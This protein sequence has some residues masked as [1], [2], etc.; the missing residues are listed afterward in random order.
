MQKICVVYVIIAFFALSLFDLN[1][2]DVIHYQ[3]NFLL[4]ESCADNTDNEV[5][6]REANILPVL[7]YVFFSFAIMDCSTKTVWWKAD[8]PVFW[9]CKFRIQSPRCKL[10]FSNIRS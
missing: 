7:I 8:L 4:I 2:F 9:G 6:A 1:D 10:T 3:E 5:M